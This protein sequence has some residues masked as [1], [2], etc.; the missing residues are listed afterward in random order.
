ME[1]EILERLRNIE[2]M[3]AATLFLV[4]LLGVSFLAYLVYNENGGRFRRIKDLS[5]Q[6]VVKQARVLQRRITDLGSAIKPKPDIHPIIEQ[7]TARHYL[8]HYQRTGELL[9]LSP[10]GDWLEVIRPVGGVRDDWVRLVD[11]WKAENIIRQHTEGATGGIGARLIPCN[12]GRG[13][14]AKMK[15]KAGRPHPTTAQK[16]RVRVPERG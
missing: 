14:I 2:N 1:R 13:M 4:L 7:A 16:S 8:E 9:N 6:L 11:R 12:D 3:Q 5:K 15:Q 10:E